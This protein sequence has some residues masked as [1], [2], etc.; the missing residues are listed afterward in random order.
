[1][2]ITVFTS[3]DCSNERSLVNSLSSKS[4]SVVLDSRYVLILAKLNDMNNAAKFDQVKS[5]ESPL[6][7][8]AKSCLY[9]SKQNPGVNHTEY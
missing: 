9:H 5:P 1:M 6:D 3:T 8:C 7:Y 2:F 4:S